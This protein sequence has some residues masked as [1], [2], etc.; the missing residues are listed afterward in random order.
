MAKQKRFSILVAV[1]VVGGLGMLAT[2]QYVERIHGPPSHIVMSNSE[3]HAIDPTGNLLCE[4]GS[5]LCNGWHVP[6]WFIDYDLLGDDGRESYDEY[7]GR[8]FAKLREHADLKNNGMRKVL[9]VVHGGLNSQRDAIRRAE[10]LT[11]IIKNSPESYYPI[12]IN[13]DSSFF[14]SYYDYLFHI[15]QGEY[16]PSW[17]PQAWMLALVYLASDTVRGIVQMPILWF[18]EVKK[19]E[20][21]EWLQKNVSARI[22]LPLGSTREQDYARAAA[23]LMRR[24][25]MHPDGDVIAIWEGKDQ[26]RFWPEQFWSSLT[27][28]L[29]LPFK[30]VLA[31]LLDAYSES[32]FRMNVRR[33]HVQFHTDAEFAEKADGNYQ[34]ADGAL[35]VFMR[36]LH[37]EYR[38]DK[39]R[40]P[41]LEWDITLVGHSMGTM[42]L[43]EM[44]RSYG[45]ATVKNAQG[46]HVEEALP[47]NQIVYMAAA[48][49]IRDYENSL[50]PYLRKNPRAHFYHLTL[51][52]E[53]EER[54]RYDFFIPYLDPLPRGS[55]LVWMDDFMSN[56]LSYLDLTLG[57]FSNLM[58]AVHD[59]PDQIRRQISIK[60]FGAG[61]T[62]DAPQEHAQFMTKFKFWAKEC[63]QPVTQ[64]HPECFNAT[65]HY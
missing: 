34:D 42:I 10:R 59:T 44:V 3:G 62:V 43:N 1:V 29:T 28:V 58:V 13:W 27:W 35:A 38:L 25:A 15:R 31:P 6:A 33:T 18:S 63:W 49:T 21:E 2:H 61:E 8:L 48:C 14:S 56:P 50:F 23:T 55:I 54:E 37:H 24:H 11:E 12:F 47:F 64:N 30:I 19:T 46:R 32:S 7:L 45:I 52:E 60:A 17:Y 5:A 26:Q 39:E 51:H 41:R 65:G 22:S 53:A 36:R 20:P 9:I 57:R 16:Y 4:S 40:N